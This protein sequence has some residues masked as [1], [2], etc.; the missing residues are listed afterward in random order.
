MNIVVLPYNYPNIYS[1]IS[2][3]FIQD[4]AQA[5]SNLG[6]DVRVVGAV[7]I[8]LKQVFKRKKIYFGNVKYVKNNVSVR[9]FLY[10][11]VPKLKKLNNFFRN[12]INNF[13]LN[14]SHK[15]KPIDV[16][17]VH[18]SIAGKSA[19][20]MYEKKHIPY[21]I[22]EHS[23]AYVRNLVSKKEIVEYR[24]IYEYASYRIAVSKQFCAVLKDIFALE[25]TYI[26]NIVNQDFF[27]RKPKKTKKE[28]IFINVA[29]LLKNK[30]Q[31]LLIK[32]FAKKFREENVK[33]HILGAGPE[34]NNLQNLIIK[35]NVKDKIILFGKSNRDKVIYELQKSDVFVL[36]SIYETFGV[37]LIEAMA[38]GLPVVSTKC[39]GPESI[40]T[41]KNLGELVESNID[42]LSAAMYK[43]YNN[44]RAYDNNE[45][46]NFVEDNFSEKV[47]A[48]KLNNILNNVVLLNGKMFNKG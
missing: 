13:L 8:S 40:I 41:N 23:S 32:A 35:L 28:I 3:I 19:F 12:V 21:I 45:I 1:D 20:N 24:N 36:S 18:N 34:Y 26:P 38:C 39:G 10:P 29:N 33:L 44:L 16:I 15:H 4:Q 31:E 37:V 46:S 30:N 11:S 27:F 48:N 14:K 17:H 6:L 43:V 42:E 5:M 9:L 7:P 2:A 25:F 22:T 47:I